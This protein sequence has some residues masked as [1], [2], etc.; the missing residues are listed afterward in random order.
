MTGAS[1]V[2]NVKLV[3]LGKGYIDLL[4]WSEGKGPLAC[5]N[6]KKMKSAVM[7][8][9]HAHCVPGMELNSLSVLG[10]LNL[11]TCWNGDYY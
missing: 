1:Q 6:S 9:W 8:V 4:I 11:A 3:L 2:L 10:D 5:S 7:I